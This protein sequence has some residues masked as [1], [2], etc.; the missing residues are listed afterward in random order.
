MPGP[1]APDVSPQRYPRQAQSSDDA[2]TRVTCHQPR[3]ATHF[4]N[5]RTT[6]PAS[7]D[8]LLGPE[9]SAL[10]RRIVGFEPTR[11]FARWINSPVPDH[12][13]FGEAK[14]NRTLDLP[15]LNPAAL[16]L[17]YNLG[18]MTRGT[19]LPQSGARQPGLSEPGHIACRKETLGYL[20]FWAKV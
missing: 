19:R 12:R 9:P 10:C 11:A 2:A 4:A 17:S 7:R 1:K 14:G 16:P 6:R 3:P 8:Q 15:D 20:R 18:L 13:A 5:G